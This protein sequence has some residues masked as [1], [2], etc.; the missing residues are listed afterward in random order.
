MLR[1]HHAL[2]DDGP[3]VPVV[4]VVSAFISGISL[5]AHGW[6]VWAILLTEF[7]SYGS[8]LL[9]VCGLDYLL[10][11]RWAVRI[12]PVDAAP[13]TKETFRMSAQLPFILAAVFGFAAL[14][15]YRFLVAP[16]AGWSDRALWTAVVAALLAFG[17]GW[18]VHWLV[19]REESRTP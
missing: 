14:L 19:R 9:L 8:G 7:G 4:L 17:I 18:F 12:E 3:I 6:P 5:A 13:Q 11:R 10:E 2:S 16:V 1:D 15:V